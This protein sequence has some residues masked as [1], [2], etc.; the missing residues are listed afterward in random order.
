V[1]TPFWDAIG[2]KLADRWMSAAS[3]A[4]VFWAGGVATWVVGHGGLQSLSPAIV[5]LTGQSPAAQALVL[6]AGLLVLAA[7]VVVVQRAI[8]PVARLLEGY[9]PGWLGFARRWL[10]SRRAAVAERLEREWQDLAPKVD[11]GDAS[12]EERR[13]YIDLDRRQR[14]VPLDERR[15]PTRFG[16]I[17]S[18]AEG[19]P[20]DKYGLDT[21]KCWPRL[22]LVLPDAVRQDLTSARSNLD[23]AV[24]TC[25]WGFLFIGFAVWTPWAALVGLGVSVLGYHFWACSR[26]E[27]FGDLV[28]SAF[29][30]HRADLYR[31]LR[32]PLPTDPGRERETGIALTMYLWR[33]AD[34]GPALT[35]ED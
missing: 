2:G 11:R 27:V 3:P 25:V 8:E 12:A 15:M 19:L 35:T 1:L 5:W 18:A 33:G 32:W 20:F 29:D 34:Q 14:R 31:A 21:L 17:L 22:W 24:A 16:D 23:T 9:W 13:R 7:S 6:A 4:L 28:E 10:T 26:A 30:T